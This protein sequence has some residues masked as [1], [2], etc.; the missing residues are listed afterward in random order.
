M[1]LRYSSV[2]VLARITTKCVKIDENPA[3]GVALQELTIYPD[4]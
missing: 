1:T 2:V 4:A 3:G